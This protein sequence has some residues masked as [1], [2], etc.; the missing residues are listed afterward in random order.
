MR[1][2]SKRPTQLAIRRLTVALGALTCL[3]LAASCAS[4][5]DQL[6]ARKQELRAL[7]EQLFQTYGG[8]QL[9]QQIDGASRE[10]AKKDDVGGLAQMIGNFAKDLD[11][12]V[13]LQDCQRLGQ[14]E[15]LNLLTDKAKA[16]F[17]KPETLASC[18]RM[19]DLQRE[20]DAL[21]Q[22]VQ[23]GAPKM[24]ATPEDGQPSSTP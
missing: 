1:H 22:K 23:G 8:S 7:E 11:R 13:F 9:A 20:V 5:Q 14:G 4:P 18:N 6:R 19:V 2:F 16:F 3:L 24:E 10:A 17:A 21:E 12:D 15:R